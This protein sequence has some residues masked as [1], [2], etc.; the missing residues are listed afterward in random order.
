[1]LLKRFWP[2]PCGAN[3][4]SSRNSLHTLLQN[5]IA[6][7]FASSIK[8]VGNWLPS[9]QGQCCF[10]LKM[11]SFRCH[12]GSFC[13]PYCS[14]CQAGSKNA[15]ARA[16]LG[17]WP[18]G[19]RPGINFIVRSRTSRYSCLDPQSPFVFGVV[20]CCIHFWGVLSFLGVLVPCL[21]VFVFPCAALSTL[22]FR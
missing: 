6:E 3:W 4:Q 16:G 18:C 17:S 1:M 22:Q 21:G 9:G 7:Q 8:H 13:T 10:E 20:P 14:S 11:L 5:S 2:Q 19:L 12:R 15:A